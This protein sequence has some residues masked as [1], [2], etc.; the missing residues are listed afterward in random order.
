MRYFLHLLNINFYFR[1]GIGKRVC[2]R[3]IVGPVT[4]S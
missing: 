1:S 4:S 2:M 3:D